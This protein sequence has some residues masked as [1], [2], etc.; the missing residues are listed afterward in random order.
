M[1]SNSCQV[2]IVGG[3]VF[4]GAI[5]YQLARRGLRPTL[6][7][8]D[9]FGSHASGKNAGNL[10]PIHGSPSALLPLALE[11]FR[12]HQKLANELTELGRQSNYLLAAKRIHLVFEESDT[13][14]S[15]TEESDTLELQKNTAELQRIREA[16][17]GHSGFSTSWLDSNELHEMEPR[18]APRIKGGLLVE[19]NLSLD[20]R[21]FTVA[22][23]E[24]AA[25]MGTT[26]VRAIVTGVTTANGKVTAVRTT[27]NEIPCDIVVFTTGPWV[28]ELQSWLGV[29]LPVEPLKGEMLRMKLPGGGLKYDFTH[30]LISLYNRSHGEIWVGVTKESVGLDES[31]T[32]NGKRHLLEAAE[33]IMPAIQ[34][35]V[36][37]E[38]TASLRPTTPAGLPIVAQAPGWKNA[39]IANGGGIKGILLCTGIAEAAC[40]LILS[41]HTKVASESLH[42]L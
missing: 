41:G 26:L 40:N 39:Y 12:L 25:R 38:H 21:A 4:G 13:E 3:G 34:Q 9:E 28:E 17:V 2:V 7:D 22:L 33:R 31:S 16:F 23:A 15:D 24:G 27:H 6:I 32:E 20:G 19:G 11:S 5:A 37:L 1:T 10:N 30:G 42:Q 29:V 18:L 36:I 14:E 8:R 35:A